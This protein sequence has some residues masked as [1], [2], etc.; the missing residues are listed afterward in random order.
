MG[1]S[2]ILVYEKAT[3]RANN[4]QSVYDYYQEHGAFP[5]PEAEEEGNEEAAPV[6]VQIAPLNDMEFV[7][8]EDL[9]EEDPKEDPEED[10]EEFNDPPQNEA[11]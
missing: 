7:V 10:P 6:L 11:D 4:D 1:I 5:L 8:E 2:M 3:K 9:E